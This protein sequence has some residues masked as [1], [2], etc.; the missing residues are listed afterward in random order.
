M[1]IKINSIHF[2]L[3]KKLVDFIESKVEKLSH[4][5]DDILAAE[6]HLSLERSQQKNVDT[7][8]TKIKLEIPGYDLFAEKMA[9]TFEEATDSAIEALK[10]QI[11]K[12]KEKTINK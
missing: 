9:G 2:N 4:Y 11:G 8:V 1:N 12:R 7:K 3:D 6:V 5:S 10:R